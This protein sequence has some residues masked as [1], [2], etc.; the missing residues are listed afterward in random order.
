M[1]DVGC[2]DDESEGGA[3]M[4]DDERQKEI[5]RRTKRDLNEPIS[6]NCFSNEGMVQA[7]VRLARSRVPHRATGFLKRLPLMAISNPRVSQRVWG[8]TRGGAWP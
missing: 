2:E 7:E 6:V 3:T 8:G 1:Y 4:F 5:R